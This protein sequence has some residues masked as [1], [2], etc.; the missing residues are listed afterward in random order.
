MTFT[1]DIMHTNK[2]VMQKVKGK[3]KHI[4]R[5]YGESTKEPIQYTDLLL[6]FSLLQLTRQN[7]DKPTGILKFL[8]PLHNTLQ[9]ISFF[10]HIAWSNRELSIY[11]KLHALNMEI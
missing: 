3:H 6:S 11:S 5:V 7:K 8:I 2:N 1:I 4:V 10:V 9:F